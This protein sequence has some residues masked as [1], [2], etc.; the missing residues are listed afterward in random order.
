M[1]LSDKQLA[2]SSYDNTINVW[3]L[4]TGDCLMT[5]YG[6]DKILDLNLLSNNSIICCTENK[7]IKIWSLITGRCLNT[8]QA[9]TDIL[10]ICIIK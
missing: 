8:L 7:I 10:R 2:S 5:F 9:N 3:H 4:E 6:Q 1:K